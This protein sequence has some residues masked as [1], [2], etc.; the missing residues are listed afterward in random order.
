MVTE[1][2]A[3]KIA[4]KEAKNTTVIPAHPDRVLVPVANPA[5]AGRLI[6]AALAFRDKISD[7]ESVFALALIEENGPG[8]EDRLQ[9]TR[10]F[11]NDIVVAHAENEKYLRTLLKIDI[12]VVS[13][14]IKT[15]K[16]ISANHLVLGW[17]G[18]PTTA[19]RLFGNLLKRIISEVPEMII[20]TRHRQPIHNFKTLQLW[21]QPNAEYETGFLGMARKLVEISFSIQARLDIYS[22]KNLT[23]YFS[24]IS[25]RTRI[26]CECKHIPIK[27]WSESVLS[28]PKTESRDTLFAYVMARRGTLSF[29]NI[30]EELPH[31]LNSLPDSTSFLVVYPE[32]SP[33]LRH[34]GV[35]PAEE[36]FNTPLT[37]RLSKTRKNLQRILSYFKLSSSKSIQ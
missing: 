18:L 29:H 37:S 4:I 31:F 12:N 30:H 16:E 26:L 28:K 20:V 7:K 11:L 17:G 22:E 15:M 33:I 5:T 9:Q 24:L 36:I 13:G 3:R 8:S 14:I 32:Q 21:I 6:E 1:S 25:Q 23:N 10:K 27:S 19:D 34:S 2:A 35:I